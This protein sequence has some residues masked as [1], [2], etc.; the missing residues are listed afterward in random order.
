MTHCLIC[1]ESLLDC[2]TLDLGSL[3]ACNQFEKIE[4]VDPRTHP[5]SITECRA[6]SLVQL[7]KYHPL[8]L[9]C[10]RLPWI[11][12]NEPFGHLDAVVENLKDLIPLGD[13]HVAM[14]VGP[15]DE[16]LLELM[17]QIGFRHKQLDFSEQLEKLPERFPYLESIQA[18]L[19]PEVLTELVPVQGTSIL[20]T[21][22]Y[23]LEHS[24]NPVATM[25]GLSN[26]LA[27]DGLLLIEVPDSS[28]FLAVLDYSFIWEENISY[29]TE[30]TFRICALQAGYEVVQ[31]NRYPGVLEDALVFVLRFDKN[32]LS[33]KTFNCGL[34][35][36]KVFTR[37]QTEFQNVKQQY[38]SALQAITA[39]GRKVVIFGAGHQSIMFVNALGLKQHISYVI[40]DAPE[41]IG[42]LIPGTSIPIVPSEHLANDLSIDLCLLGISPNLEEKIRSK[43]AEFLQRGGQMYSIFPGAQTSPYLLHRLEMQ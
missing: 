28:K 42:Y 3:V 25:H 12:Y 22:R 34:D 39:Q 17:S 13:K 7:S 36:S 8:D 41:K 30:Q 43:C 29:F 40:D 37:Y 16:P 26:L 2:S 18:L 35:N 20:V 23:L 24:H 9:V 4:L 6:C 14:G 19:R 15:F 11:R 27:E 38:C 32:P 21:C 1:G 33:K 31:F 10:P 5:L